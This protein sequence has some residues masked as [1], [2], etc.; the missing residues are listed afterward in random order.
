MINLKLNIVWLSIQSLLIFVTSKLD[1]QLRGLNL[2]SKAGLI[3]SF[4]GLIFTFLLSPLNGFAENYSCH[5]LLATAGSL[6]ETHYPLMESSLLNSTGVPL[7]SVR[8]KSIAL[9][10]ATETH[11]YLKSEIEKKMQSE[12]AISSP[13]KSVYRKMLEE[14]SERFLIKSY[15]A[16]AVDLLGEQMPNFSE[17]IRYIKSEIKISIRANRPFHMMPILLLGDAGVGK[18]RFA[19]EL[20]KALGL[21]ASYISMN[22]VT[23]GWYLS[24]ASSQWK[25]SKMGKIAEVLMES[26]MANPVIMLDEIDKTSSQAQYNPM[27]P[28]YSLLEEHTAKVFKDE[29][30]EVALNTSHIN[31]IATANDIASIPDPIRSRLLIF[32]IRK[33]TELEQVDI[34]HRIFA[35]YLS[36][37][38]DLHFSAHL[39]AEVLKKLKG[40]S[41]RELKKV[42]RTSVGRAI[43]EDRNELEARD[44]EV[45]NLES[46]RPSIGF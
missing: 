43:L 32:N 28:F 7:R 17:V 33:P 26:H 15:K 14:P 41:P 39:D 9:L 45:Q 18:T 24:G 35:E 36:A 16:D 11:L 40:I 6:V 2:N 3:L 27:A 37:N 23:A 34:I 42:L 13:L 20:A 22:N 46:L 21:D 4:C 19:F 30:L 38:K 5:E 8:Q 44:I 1:F 12:G 25:D 29:F 31:W 10:M